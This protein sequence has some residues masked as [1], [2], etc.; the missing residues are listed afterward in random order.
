MLNLGLLG[1][2]FVPANAR[3]CP[4]LAFNILFEAFSDPQLRLLLLSLSAHGK[5]H[6]EL[7]DWLFSST[8][9]CDR[10][11]VFTCPTP[12]PQP[13][14][15]PSGRPFGSAGNQEFLSALL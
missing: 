12:C 9:P 7:L 10:W 4:S 3:S 13:G 6:T 8:G 15:D 5:G 11:R 14:G 1:G 2:I